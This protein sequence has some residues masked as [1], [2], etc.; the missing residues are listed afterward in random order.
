[1]SRNQIRI[2]PMLLALGLASGQPAAANSQQSRAPAAGPVRPAFAPIAIGRRR[3]CREKQAV[4]IS[5]GSQKV[6]VNYF[7][8]LVI[9]T[10][11][12]EK[13]VPEKLIGETISLTRDPKQNERWIIF[14]GGA[15]DGDTL[16]MPENVFR[17][18]KV[19]LSTRD[20]QV[21]MKVGDQDYRLE[22][23]EVLFL[24]G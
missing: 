10:I 8:E 2:L 23:G 5:Q 6:T 13:I 7:T 18:E 24:L 1:M 9:A 19:L 16:A 12:D 14:R 17:I 11:N 21:K 20:K 4:E 15:S 22:P 3:I